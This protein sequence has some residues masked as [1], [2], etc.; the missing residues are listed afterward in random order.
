MERLIRLLG[1]ENDLD[2]INLAL[3]YHVEAQRPPA[4]GAMHI[5][6]S[7]ESERECSEAFQK[8]FVDPLLPQIKFWQRAPFRCANLGGRY[9]W[10]ALPIAEQHF[11]VPASHEAFKMLVLKINSHVAVGENERR[12][13]FGRMAR[14]E[15]DSLA[16][17]A[18]HALLD[19]VAMPFTHELEE[20]F[21]SEGADRLAALRDAEKIDPSH[22]A[23]LAAIVSVRLQARHAVLDIQ[24][25]RP[26]TPTV[27]VIVACVTLNRS[28]ADR[29]LLCGYYTADRRRHDGTITYRGLGDDPAL[30]RLRFGA[31]RVHVEDDHIH[32]DRP[33]RDHRKLVGQVWRQ[34]TGQPV[35][36]ATA[37]APAPGGQHHREQLA[38]V[39]AE[40]QAGK[41]HKHTYAKPMLRMMLS[42]LMEVSPVPAAVIL[43]AEG[44]ASIYHTHRAH[45]MARELH[46]HE[47][48]R[49]VLA[50]VHSRIDKLGPERAREIID[51]LVA[52]EAS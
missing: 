15:S 13:L 47:D 50:E 3:R 9:E 44:F 10:G 33:A 28:G 16:C 26:T 23:L 21:V 7:D 20:S 19:G 30:Y 22:R 8:T 11:A 27:Y 5:T 45:R 42:A 36:Q 46:R 38:Q 39:V 25:Y 4:V 34:R 43:F 35:E 29:E 40:A 12:P 18:I 51:V 48:A 14:Y 49:R 17:G 32:V 31:S 6:C 37:S 52:Q 2:D 41:H 24:D 1:I